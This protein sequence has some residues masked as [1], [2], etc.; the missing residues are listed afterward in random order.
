MPERGAFRPAS[1]TMK[2][3]LA[4]IDAK[5]GVVG[6]PFEPLLV[7]SPPARN[8]QCRGMMDTS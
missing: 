3:G 6:D 5:S 8:S 7:P 1:G 4:T 2:D